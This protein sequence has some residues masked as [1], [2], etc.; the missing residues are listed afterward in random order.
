MNLTTDSLHNPMRKEDI[1][2]DFTDNKGD[3]LT[4]KI[5]TDE[6]QQII[7]RSPVRS[8]N[9]TSPNLWLVGWINHKI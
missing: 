4:W 9:K 3:Q 7:T 1:G 6:T 8:A 2:L 5:L